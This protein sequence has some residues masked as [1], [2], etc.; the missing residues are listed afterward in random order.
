MAEL[1]VPALSRSTRAAPAIR[2]DQLIAAATVAPMAIFLLVTLGGGLPTSLAV[3]TLFLGGPHVLATLGLYLDD[4]ISAVVRGDLRRYVVWP[5]LVVPAVALGFGL[6]RGQ[7]ALWLLSG[8][9]AWQIY[10]FSKQNL[11]M[12]AFWTRARGLAAMTTGERRLLKATAVVG[13]LGVLRTMD[14]VPRWSTSFQVAGLAVTA[15]LALAAVTIGDGRRR[16]ALLLA[17]AFYLPVHLF[18]VDV[19]SAAF[20]YQAA[21][22]AQYYLMVG[23]VI[24][25]DRR[26]ARATLGIVLVGGVVLLAITAPASLVATPWL[27]GLGKGVVAAHFVADASFW[28]LR[29]PEVRAVMKDRFSFL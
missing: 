4:Q 5:L 27:F 13:I 16:L 9:L 1:D 2:F 18:S 15:A 14:L 23:H 29:R 19:T 25:V 28:Q 22:G 10:H 12:F 17:A 3:L 11:G 21:H 6:A 24:R 20:I 8:L 7:L 26:T